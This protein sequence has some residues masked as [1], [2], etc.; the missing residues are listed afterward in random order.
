M[1]H[2]SHLTKTFESA[3]DVHALK[4][5]SLDISDGDIFGIIGI[6]GAGKSTLVR[7]LNMLERPTSGSI[8]VDGIEVCK[9][10]GRELH[11]Y[12]RRVAMIFQAFGLLAQK[13]VLD[14][15]CFPF[16]ASKGTVSAQDKQ[17]AQDLLARVG[18]ASKANAYPAQ[19]SGG[20]QQRVAIARALACNPEYIL[21]DEATSALDPAST[22]SVLDLLKTI[23]KETGVTIIIIT[24]SMDVVRSTCNNVAVLCH[25]EIVEKGNVEQVFA[26]PS[27]KI[28]KQLLGVEDWHE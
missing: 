8:E 12:R 9:L 17:T 5:V 2:I 6:S 22:A 16:L 7:C 13:T 23:N 24:H 4:D 11:E 26:H 18:L 3:S 20:Q 10:K 28:T 15:V 1:I 19:L 25:G 21:C 14:N 27:H